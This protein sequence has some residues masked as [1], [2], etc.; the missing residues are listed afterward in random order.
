M[1][2][3]RSAAPRTHRQEPPS[4]PRMFCV[5]AALATLGRSALLRPEK[6]TQ[7]GLGGG[8]TTG[9][10]AG[11]DAGSSRSMARVARDREY[12]HAAP[13]NRRQSRVDRGRKREV[14]APSRRRTRPPTLPTAGGG[15]AA[16]FA[17]SVAAADTQAEKS[18]LPQA[19]LPWPVARMRC[20]VPAKP[21]GRQPP[22]IAHRPGMEKGCPHAR[23]LRHQRMP[24]W[25]GRTRNSNAAAG[26]GVRHHGVL[27]MNHRGG[28]EVLTM[29]FLR[30]YALVDRSRRILRDW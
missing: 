19:L 7:M 21:Q 29:Q 13:Q 11:S 23:T 6:E 22:P 14:A 18:L 17:G 15:A 27:A 4:P 26:G 1:T 10:S 9:P 30:M 3:A 8:S 12:V 28:G 25:E 5:S 24:A 2:G 20:Y 16:S